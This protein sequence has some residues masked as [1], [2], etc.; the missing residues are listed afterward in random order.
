[1]TY[2]HHIISHRTLYC[3]K[4]HLSSAYSSLPASSTFLSF[5]PHQTSDLF[6]VS[7][8]LPFPK[9]HRVA[10]IYFEAFSDWL[11]SLSSIYLR[12]PYF[13]SWFDSS[14]FL[15]VLSHFC[16]VRLFVTPWAVACQAPLSMGFS[17]QEYRSGLPFLPPGELLNP[18]IE[19]SSP[20]SFVLQAD[21]LPVERFRE[22]HLNVPQ[23]IH[24]PTEDIMIASKF[25][26]FWIMI[27]IKI[28]VQI[29]V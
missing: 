21:S 6:I 13:F 22:A 8:F 29:S 27:L 23:F 18:G 24:S 4:N 16:C 5:S 25:W 15:C 10:I 11:L 9:C 28:H 7:I 14:F 12:V 26:Q 17:K 19:P 20:V 1:M 3:P 2:I